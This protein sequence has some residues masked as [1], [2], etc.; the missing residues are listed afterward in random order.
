MTEKITRS[1]NLRLQPATTPS[2]TS[3]TAATPTTTAAIAATA[4]TTSVFL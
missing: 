2:T 4:A 3:A 1:E